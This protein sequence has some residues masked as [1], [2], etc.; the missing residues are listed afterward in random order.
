MLRLPVP[1]MD[2]PLTDLQPALA[3]DLLRAEHARIA[4]AFACYAA[5]CAV[6]AE[7]RAL[8]T[9]LV[10]TADLHLA[11]ERRMLYP[12]VRHEADALVQRLTDD[13]AV[14]RAAMDAAITA[15]DAGT[16]DAAVA[17]LGRLLRDHAAAEE[18]HLFPQVER[19]LPNTL[20]RLGGDLARRRA[21]GRADVPDLDPLLDFAST[22]A[23]AR[24][25]R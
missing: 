17:R 4:A 23:L 18:E 16:R 7:R 20:R 6:D 19:H 25:L 21:A 24:A 12:L 9:A 15:A 10:A 1:L 11:T 2:T 8:A 13:H 3:T 5:A 14:I 22:A